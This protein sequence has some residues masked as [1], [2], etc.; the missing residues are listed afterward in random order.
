MHNG[1]AWQYF[2]QVHASLVLTERQLAEHY[3]S[4]EVYARLRN[5]AAGTPADDERFLISSLQAVELDLLQGKP[6]PY[7]QLVSLVD[8][9]RQRPEIFP[10]WQTSATAELFQ[11]HA[12]ENK[13]NSSGY[14]F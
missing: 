1:K 9:I 13:K 8:H 3:I 2:E 5:A 11:P 14:W 4:I 10:E 12:F 6:L 7:K